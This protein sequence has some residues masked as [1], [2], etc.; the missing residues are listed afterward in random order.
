M[1]VSLMKLFIHFYIYALKNSQTH[2]FLT[3]KYIT[4]LKNIRIYI[5][6]T[7]PASIIDPYI[8]SKVTKTCLFLWLWQRPVS[9]ESAD[10]GSDV[11]TLSLSERKFGAQG[12]DETAAEKVSPES[13]ILMFPESLLI[14]WSSLQ[15]LSTTFI[16][17]FLKVH[18]HSKKK[19]KKQERKERE[20]Q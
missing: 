8:Y 12:K 20:R 14:P 7:N 18:P 13:V 5:T 9:E 6:Q 16:S 10:N 19:R 4:Y 15:A 17:L 2:L 11:V 1:Y 3:A